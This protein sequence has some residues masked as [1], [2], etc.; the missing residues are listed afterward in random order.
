MLWSD[1]QYVKPI[2]SNVYFP[3]YEVSNM[4]YKGVLLGTNNLNL[5][6]IPLTD[7]QI[8]V[9]VINKPIYNTNWFDYVRGDGLTVI[10]TD[11][12]DYSDYLGSQVGFDLEG[13]NLLFI[14]KNPLYNSEIILIDAQD[15]VSVSN[16]YIRYLTNDLTGTEK[17]ARLDMS[18]RIF[19]NGIE[20]MNYTNIDLLPTGGSLKL[21]DSDNDGRIDY[22]FITD[23]N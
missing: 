18:S 7:K 8:V 9:D 6:N 10:N 21:V 1:I 11:G 4:P 20:I 16:G 2:V 13:D 22:V 23:Y 15:I 17:Y 5:T 19:K 14:N 3:R 12:K